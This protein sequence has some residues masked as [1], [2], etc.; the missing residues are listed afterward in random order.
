MKENIRARIQSRICTAPCFLGNE[1]LLILWAKI[2][3]CISFSFPQTSVFGL[4]TECQGPPAR[5]Q[6]WLASLCR[7]WRS[8]TGAWGIRGNADLRRGSDNHQCCSLLRAHR[9][10]C[11]TGC[12]R[13]AIWGG[14]N[15]APP[16]AEPS[17]G[18]RR[19]AQ[20]SQPSSSG[21]G[22]SSRG[23]LQV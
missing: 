6:L 19:D 15:S 10:T 17:V 12:S 23:Q 5:S 18:P 9:A 8:R 4:G 11:I 13:A 1:R 22:L 21:F 2:N 16:T 14:R 7:Q 20:E 3:G